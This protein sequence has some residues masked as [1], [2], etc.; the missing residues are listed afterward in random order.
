MEQHSTQKGHNESEPAEA[1]EEN[2]PNPPLRKW[3]S[4]DSDS[5]NPLDQG[6]SRKIII[7]HFHISR[8]GQIGLIY[9][10]T[11]LNIDLA[12]PAFSF[13]QIDPI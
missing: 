12:T 6:K 9:I 3:G 2:P 10:R 7:S 11:I 8:S 13:R 4:R 1:G 5:H